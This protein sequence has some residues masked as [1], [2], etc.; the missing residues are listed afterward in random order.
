[1]TDSAA[2][3]IPAPLPQSKEVEKQPTA[4]E[5]VVEDK[6]SPEASSETDK[7]EPKKEAEPKRT[8][9]T[10]TEAAEA[11][12]PT[13]ESDMETMEPDMETVESNMETE[14]S[15][16]ETMESDSEV[17]CGTSGASLSEYKVGLKMC[18]EL[19]TT[20]DLKVL[21]ASKNDIYQ[22]KIQAIV[23]QSSLSPEL[24]VACLQFIFSPTP[25]GQIPFVGT[26]CLDWISG[27]LP[28]VMIV[29]VEKKDGEAAPNV[30]AEFSGVILKRVFAQIFKVP[31]TGAFREDGFVTFG[32]DTGSDAYTG[33]WC[34]GDETIEGIWQATDTSQG[35]FRMTILE[36][37]E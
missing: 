20:D 14:K 4:P 33:V 26:A 19:K 3:H 17:P 27:A 18:E 12:K 16:M 25:G 31:T 29:E 6:R 28:Q 21:A 5:K 9:E 11:V 23:E 37:D 13:V 24:A 7:V 1:M 35:T 34:T 22:K 15:D 2:P 10:E 30:V 8:A 36:D 32:A